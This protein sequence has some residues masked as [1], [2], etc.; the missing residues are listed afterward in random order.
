MLF[1]GKLFRLIILLI[2]E[3]KS[4]RCGFEHHQGIEN[5]NRQVLSMFTTLL[6]GTEKL[7]VKSSKC[8]CVLGWGRI[9][10]CISI[11]P[12][13]L[14]IS[15]DMTQNVLSNIPALGMRKVRTK[16]VQ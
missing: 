1:P 15:R 11:A 4:H 5:L 12:F 3:H 6:P 16:K 2:L 8:V 7:E 10:L 13:I 9:I 14:F